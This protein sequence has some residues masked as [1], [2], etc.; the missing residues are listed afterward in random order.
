MPWCPEMDP[1]KENRPAS[2]PSPTPAAV[3]PTP[4]EKPVL[5]EGPR[6]RFSY[7]GRAEADPESKTGHSRK[8]WKTLAPVFALCMATLVIFYAHSKKNF[9][10]PAS[11]APGGSADSLRQGPRKIPPARK[12]T[13]LSL[14]SSGDSVGEAEAAQNFSKSNNAASEEARAASQA[15]I[16]SAKARPDVR[17]AVSFYKMALSFNKRNIDAWYGLINA[18]TQASMPEEADKARADMKKIFGDGVFSIAQAVGRFGDL[19]DLSATDEGTFRVEYRSRQTGQNELIHESFL[20]GKALAVQCRCTA[21]SLYIHSAGDKG[22]SAGALVFF[23]TSPLP[24][25]FEGFQSAAA[26]TYLR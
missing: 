16:D 19:L 13:G 20:L 25:T 11:P 7:I 22:D 12:K 17:E 23:K 4:A 14:S 8:A 1:I 18:Y 9:R 15:F 6:P 5:S 3:M 24:L 2:G 21:I 26:V 10:I